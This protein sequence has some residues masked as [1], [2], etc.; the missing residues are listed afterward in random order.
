MTMKL[1]IKPSYLLFDVISLRLTNDDLTQV[2]LS[3]KKTPHKKT[4]LIIY[5]K[6]QSAYIK[7]YIKNKEGGLWI[8][9][10]CFSSINKT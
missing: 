8:Q 5:T 7:K 4:R 1:I 10:F 3:I 6:F 9:I 2:K